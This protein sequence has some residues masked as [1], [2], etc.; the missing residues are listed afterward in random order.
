M[1]EQKPPLGPKPKIKCILCN[2]ETIPVPH[3][4]GHKCIKCGY[5][6]TGL[7]AELGKQWPPPG[8]PG[9]GTPEGG[10]IGAR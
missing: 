6:T 2:K 3:L 7:E 9:G 1:M 4:D 5:I 8:K 10:G